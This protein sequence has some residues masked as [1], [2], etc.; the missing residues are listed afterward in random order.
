[1]EL[2]YKSDKGVYI[3]GGKGLVGKGLRW[4]VA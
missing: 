3:F 4:A 1:M 2:P